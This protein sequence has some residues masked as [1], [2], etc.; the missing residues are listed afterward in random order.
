MRGPIRSVL[1]AAL[2]VCAFAG[3]TAGQA[4][5]ALLKEN[6][7]ASFLAIYGNPSF[8]E[9][10]GKPI[11]GGL[12]RNFGFGENMVFRACGTCT[13]PIGANLFI[14]LAGGAK[15]EAKDAYISGTLMSN[16]TGA[17]NPLSFV[18]Q[19]VDFQDSILNG[20]PTPS[21]SD[22]NDRPWITEICPKVALAVC[23]VDPLIAGNA[24][25]EVKIEDVSFDLGGNVIQ[26][27]VWGQWEDSPA[28]GSQPCIKLNPRPAGSTASQ[29]LIVTQSTVVPVGAAA[30]DV[31]GKACLISANNNWYKVKAGDEK[32]PLIEIANE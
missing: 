4:S 13:T 29:N 23:K 20:A 14:E 19:N 32:T 5:A 2:A 21:Y 30:I 3:V 27:T 28:A 24:L 1:L 7:G 26:G 9:V 16:K 12:G 8:S 18:I 10:A 22:T 6:G 31:K 25:G 11:G 15:A 17:N